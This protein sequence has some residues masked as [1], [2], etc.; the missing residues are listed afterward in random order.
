MANKHSIIPIGEDMERLI[1]HI[2]VNN[3]FLSWTAVDRLANGETFDIRT[4]PSIIG[5]DESQ[6]T[7]IV[8]AKSMPAKR[9]RDKNSRSNIFCKAKM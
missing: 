3:A 4:V 1:L 9:L 8:L 7:G 2:D 5:G 6:R